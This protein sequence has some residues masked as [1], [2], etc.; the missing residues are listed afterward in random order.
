MSRRK[1]FV[2]IS[3]AIIIAVFVTS[4]LSTTHAARFR[5]RKVTTLTWGATSPIG[6]LAT[7]AMEK[8]VKLVE[9]RSGGTLKINYFPASQLGTAMTQMEMVIK[10]NIDMFTEAQNYLADWGAPKSG[11]TSISFQIPSKEGYL[12]LLK[13]DLFKSWL[14]DFQ[15]AT[16]V[17][18][19][20][21]NWVRPPG[22]VASNI[23]VYKLE[24]MKDLKVRTLPSEIS[25]A[26]MRALGARP[27][28]VAYDEV[29]LALQQGVVD[30]TVCTTEVF[31]TMKWYE[32]TKYL[33][34]LNTSYV[35]YAIWMNEKSYQSLS[36]EHQE[37]L[38]TACNEV[39]EWYSA[40]ID[41]LVEEY[42]DKMIAHG[43]TIITY[44]PEEYARFAEASAKDA[45][46]YI[47]AGTWT[48]EEFEE[49]L[50]IVR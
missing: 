16:G 31:Y 29:Y 46:R 39:G 15:K 4:G 5:R 37:I 47:E 36:P 14:D 33:L 8:V 43:V 26:G 12:R 10:G 17:R 30:A 9:E 19:L 44:P 2:M 49:Y 35:S 34:M 18:T 20:A 1:T 28:A 25:L 6:D 38:T 11:M 32:V 13:S 45:R 48:E 27:T 21:W 23:P 40:E 22:Q 41:K 3:V 42:I 7:I 24:D 50:R